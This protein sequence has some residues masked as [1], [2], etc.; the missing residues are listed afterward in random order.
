MVKNEIFPPKLVKKARILFSPLLFNVVLNI[1]A[2]GLMR[3]R[4]IV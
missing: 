2:G 1:L 4:E 3:Q